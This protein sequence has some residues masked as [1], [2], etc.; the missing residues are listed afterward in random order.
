MSTQAQ[1]SPD[2]D[3]PRPWDGEIGAAGL[4]GPESMTWR[5]GRE[6]ALAA[7]GGARALILQVAHP[8]VAA[9][10]GENSNYRKEPW[11]RLFRTLD[12]VTA[13][14]FGTPEEA[15]EAARRVWTV[16]R[17]VRGELKQ[18]EGSFPAGTPYDARDPGL[19][20]WVH[21]TLFDT[22]VLVYDRYVKRLSIAEREAFYEEQ[23]LFAEMFGVP[24]ERQP[25]TYGDFNEYFADV[26]EHELAVTDT[27]RDVVDATLVNPPLPAAARPLRRPAVEALKLQ[28]ANSLP[29][30]LRD[31]LGL[32]WGPRRERLMRAA[33]PL[34]RGLLPLTPKLI[35]DFP[36]ARAAEKRLAAA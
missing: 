14:V 5:I 2:A 27:L 6:N 32:T 34:L 29:P 4:F 36:R 30:R 31:E 7:L 22:Q 8:L 11:D 25:E 10:V 23:K 20:L 33:E 18:V 24:R 19:A 35:R 15:E 17:K 28:T 13:I 21:A 12:A 16:H 1:T 3:W 26:V 9:G